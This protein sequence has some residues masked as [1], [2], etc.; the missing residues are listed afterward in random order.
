MKTTTKSDPEKKIQHDND[1]PMPSHDGCFAYGDG[2]MFGLS[3]TFP[4]NFPADRREALMVEME[5][6]IE[7]IGAK[8]V[9]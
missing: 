6:Q 1:P 7:I 8:R 2:M 9:G 5:R 4:L 3:F